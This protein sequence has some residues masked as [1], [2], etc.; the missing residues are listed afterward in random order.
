M[1]LWKTIYKH[2]GLSKKHLMRNN[3]A[4]HI[5]HQEALCEKSLGQKEHLGFQYL[6]FY[7]KQM[8]LF[9]KNTA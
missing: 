6:C 2:R 8:N 9:I 5:D 4:A 3:F 1:I 7:K